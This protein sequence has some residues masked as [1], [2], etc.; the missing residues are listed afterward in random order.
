MY[1]LA[2]GGLAYVRATVSRLELLVS[3]DGGGAE[4]EAGRPALAAARDE[5]ASRYS[6]MGRSGQMELALAG[7]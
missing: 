5:L 7:V 1:A 2:D 4:A 6:A 3:A